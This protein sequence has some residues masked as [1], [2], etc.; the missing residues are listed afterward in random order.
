MNDTN[1]STNIDEHLIQGKIITIRNTQVMIDKDLAKIYGVENKRLNEQVKRNIERF[2]DKFRFQ[3]TEQDIVL[4]D[5]YVDEKVLKLL[6]KRNKQ[7]QAIIYTKN[8]SKIFKL[9]LM[10]HNSQYKSITVKKFTESHDRF[11]I[12]DNKT[13][14]H[15][16]ASLKDLGQK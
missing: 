12:I 9:D 6:S 13:V 16:G 10:K 15:F 2:P 4:I 14:Y 7:V 1:N 5:N 8:L 3:P 11:L